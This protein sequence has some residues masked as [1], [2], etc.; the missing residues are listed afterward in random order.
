MTGD[1]LGTARYMSPEQAAGR[2]NLVGHRTDIFSLGVTLYE[3][4]TLHQPFGASDRQALLRQIEHDE[5]LP[6]RRL[7]SAVAIDLETII[8]KSL[9]KSRDD[10]YESAQAM[11]DDLRRFL[12][13]KP[14]LATRP[15]LMDRAA[16]WASRHRRLVASVFAVLMLAFVG[17]V[18]RRC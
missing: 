17:P 2:G 14:T 4:L 15:T 9:V 8:L 6:L 10:R 13:G 3:L 11:A 5:P 12:D 1:M 18:S 16:K 7:N